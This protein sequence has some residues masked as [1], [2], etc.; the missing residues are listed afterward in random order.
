MMENASS[1]IYYKIGNIHVIK[2]VKKIVQ[3]PV[4]MEDKT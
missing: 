4:K 2:N 1:N 3:R